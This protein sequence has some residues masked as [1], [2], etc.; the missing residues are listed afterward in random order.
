MPRCQYDKCDRIVRDPNRFSLCH[1]HLEMGEFFLW[2][3]EYVQ[4]A[5]R[6][7]GQPGA[8]RASGLV[9]PS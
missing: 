2:F 8:I 7:A 3:S 1:V 6:V 9:V 4:K 5:G